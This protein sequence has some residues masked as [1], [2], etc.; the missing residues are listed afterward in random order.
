MTPDPFQPERSPACLLL[1][2]LLSG[3]HDAHRALGAHELSLAECEI[4]EGGAA[5]CGPLQVPEN[6]DRPDG[7]MIALNVVVVPATEASTE[8]PLVDLAVR[9][10]RC[11]ESRYRTI[12][13]SYFTCRCRAFLYSF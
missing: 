2:L 5:L 1:L 8:P 3:C 4:G 11:P 10:S 7:R 6:W 13:Y 9:E 12:V